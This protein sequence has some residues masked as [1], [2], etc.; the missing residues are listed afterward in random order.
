MREDPRDSLLKLLLEGSD[1][2]TAPSCDQLLALL[3]DEGWHNVIMVQGWDLNLHSLDPIPTDVAC[4]RVPALLPLR[5][6]EL[7]GDQPLHLG[8]EVRIL[9]V[10]CNI[11]NA[12]APESEAGGITTGVDPLHLLESDIASRLLPLKWPVVA[13]THLCVRI[14][15]GVGELVACAHWVKELYCLICA[16]CHDQLRLGKVADLHDGGVVSPNAPVAWNVP[17]RPR[18]T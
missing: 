16:G 17:G 2:L 12:E 3:E 13:W 11:R 8:L 14:V 6:A 7:Q 15:A 10:R 4:L 9:G 1:Q 18:Q 5:L